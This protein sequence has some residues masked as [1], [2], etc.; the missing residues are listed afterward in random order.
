MNMFK[1]F[2]AALALGAAVLGS[3]APAWAEVFTVAVVSDT[4]NYSDVTLAQPRGA[5][6]FAQQMRYLADTREDK[7]LVFVTFVGDIVQHGDGQFRRA[8][9]DA[10]G[11]YQY[12]DTREEWDIANRSISILAASGVPFGMVLGNHDYDNYS[13]W[14]DNGPGAS[15]PLS[16]G[17]VWNLY[18]GPQSRFFAGKSW[19]GGASPDGLNSYQTFSG[20]GRQFLHL[21]LEME[22][23]QTALDWAQGVIDTHPAL[24]IMIT[25]H[26]WLKPGA[27]DRSNGYESYFPGAPNL[28]P[29]QVWDRFVRKNARIFMILSGHNYTPPV[30]GVSNGQNLRIDRNDAGLPVY[31]LIQDYQGNTVGSDGRPDTANGGAGWLRFMAF[32]TDAKKIRFYTYSTLLNRHAGQDGERTFGVAAELSQ[33]ELDFPPQLLKPAPR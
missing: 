5:D 3:T 28:S 15:K 33:F 30:E 23:P 14:S 24:P 27:Q 25:T 13:W 26:E 8:V 18:F 9:P 19:Y 32:D 16:G 31:Q 21:S 20:G 6:T 2:G 7:N 29:D 4:Q 10:E 12:F 1:R 11:Q 22:P 17:R